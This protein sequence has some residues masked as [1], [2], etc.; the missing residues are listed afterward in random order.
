MSG[1][2]KREWAATYLGP[3]ADH[4]A[5]YCA[6]QLYHKQILEWLKPMAEFLRD[7]PGGWSIPIG[8][9]IVL[10]FP[11]LFGQ[12]IVCVLTGVVWGLWVGFGLVCA[13]TFIGEVSVV[14]ATKT[15]DA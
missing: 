2:G 1:D 7:L 15:Q 6:P 10:S 3:A 8:I 13:G 11:P 12:E 4:L 14:G 9:L 5:L